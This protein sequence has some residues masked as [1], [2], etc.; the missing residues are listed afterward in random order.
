MIDRHVVD[1]SIFIEYLIAD[2]PCRDKI[3]KLFTKSRE[4]SIELY[5]TTP[6][7][8]ETLYISSRLYRASGFEEPNSEA[9]NYIS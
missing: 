5:V 6:S 9:L 1:S 8:S 7:I 3:K 2:S 4:G